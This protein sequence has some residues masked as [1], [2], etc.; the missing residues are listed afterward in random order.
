MMDSTRRRVLAWG[1][2]MGSLPAGA[3]TPLLSR[4]APGQ[5]IEP[6]YPANFRL[7]PLAADPIPEVAKPRSKAAGLASP[8]YVDPVYGTRIYKVTDAADYPDAT[9]VR[10]DYSRRQAF[11]ADNSRFIASASNGYWLLYD[12]DSFVPL[13]RAGPGGALRNMAG[14]PEAIWHP[15]LPNKL[16]F[17]S[18]GGGL[19]WWEKDVESEFDTVMA[20]FRG[21]LPWPGAKAVWTKGEGCSSADGRTFA[22]MAT[23][24]NEST[25]N[26]VIHG[27]FSYDRIEDR[28]LGTLDA[29]AFGG[30]MPDHIS[31]SVSG[32]WIVP[33]W[34]YAPKL[35]TRAYPTDFSS[36]RLLHSDS[37]HS[38][39]A[40]GARG[41]DFYVATNYQD[42]LV[43]AKDMAT[44]KSFELM[45]LYPRRG[46]S[47]GA[48]HIS[49]KAFGRPG[50]VLMSTYSD[51]AEHG[52]VKPD[53]VLQ[54]AQ[55][56]IMLLELKP[57]GRQLSVA[58]TRA[59]ARYGGYFGE[60]QATISR[61]GSRI[62]FAS[63]FD[64][65]GPPSSYL[66]VLPRQ[67]Y[68]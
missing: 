6:L 58:H 37:E 54:P 29:A 50:W 14:A 51:S 52:K 26:V 9:H 41:E 59:A 15:S 44:G 57:G 62:L 12:A 39:L 18:N 45:K 66:I 8:S 25:K 46:A 36:F 42:G 55:R 65:G 64:D 49:G 47:I 13:R 33:S 38:D 4:P 1:L 34:A 16:W 23:S 32:R 22:F 27:L 30:A 56:K 24:Y 11:N 17:T 21:R 68:D 19:V 31:V 28:I 40:I 7:K 5:P 43:V 67:V 53:P 60:H 48:A 3:V 35:G 10:H 20:D 2:G 63:N 61:D